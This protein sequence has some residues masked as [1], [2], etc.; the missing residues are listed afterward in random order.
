MVSSPR[1]ENWVDRRAI[2]LIGGYQ[3]YLSPHKGF[4]CARRVLRGGES[5]SQYVK[6][7]IAT[8]GLLAALKLSK[9][10]FA[11]CKAAKLTLQASDQKQPKRRQNNRWDCAEIAC[12][13]CELPSI[14]DCEDLGCDCTPDWGNLDCGDCSGCEVGCCD[15]GG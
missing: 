11:E 7:A 13:V 5:C 9:Q 6:Q 1:R 8:Q 15:F 2:D 10:R 12:D 4:A 3:R 14:G